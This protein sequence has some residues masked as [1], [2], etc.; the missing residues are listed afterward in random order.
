MENTAALS[1]PLTELKEETH[2]RPAFLNTVRAWILHLA[3]IAALAMGGYSL[4]SA[5][6]DLTWSQR[7]IAEAGAVAYTPGRIQNEILA[8]SAEK[9][10]TGI[11]SEHTGM[12]LIAAGLIMDGLASIIKSRR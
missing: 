2:T 5:H 7:A 6:Q 8:E 11:E 9:N 10:R 1:A 3:C 4:Y 12:L